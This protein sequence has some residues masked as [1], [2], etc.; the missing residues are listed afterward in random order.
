MCA[1]NTGVKMR[2]KKH[3]KTAN[4]GTPNQIGIVAIKTHKI[5]PF[6]SKT[7]QIEIY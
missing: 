2:W 6:G 7:K 4:E 5:R 1:T 3:D